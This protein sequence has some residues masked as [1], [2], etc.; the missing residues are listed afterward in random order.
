MVRLYPTIL[1]ESVLPEGAGDEM[2]AEEPLCDLWDPSLTAD[3]VPSSIP[4]WKAAPA[5]SVQRIL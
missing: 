3:A 2:K 1:L 5:S 4:W